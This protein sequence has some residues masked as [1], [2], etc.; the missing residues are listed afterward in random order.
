MEE[1]SVEHLLN[2]NSRLENFIKDNNLGTEFY[3]L[4]K[5]LDIQPTHE[6][7]QI[8]EDKAHADRDLKIGILGR[9]KAG[10]SSF[11]NALVFG[12]QSVL[13]K[14][15]TPMTAALTILEYGESFEA[16]VDFYTPEEVEHIKSKHAQY[17]QLLQEATERKYE[18]FKKNANLVKKKSDAELRENAKKIAAQELS[19]SSLHAHFEQYEQMQQSGIQASSL[20]SA[21][22]VECGSYSELGEKLKDYVGSSG[23]FMPFSKSITLRLNEERLKELKIIDTPGMDDP[24]VSREERTRS[25]IAACDVVFLVSPSGQFL[26]ARDLELLKSIKQKNGIKEFHIVASQ[27]DNVLSAPEIKAGGNLPQSI[28]KALANLTRQQKDIFTSKQEEY[29]AEAC[30]KFS[31]FEV[32]FSSGVSTEIANHYDNLQD[33]NAK[34]VLE[35]LRKNYPDFF[36]TKE[37][38]LSNLNLL[39]NTQKVLQI[40]EQVR[41]QKEA[42]ITAALQE[43]LQ[44]KLKSLE[45]FAKGVASALQ[46]KVD[47]LNTLDLN[48]LKEQLKKLEKIQTKVM[49]IADEA[50]EDTAIALSNKLRE[51]LDQQIK[52]FFRDIERAQ[53]SSQGSRTEERTKRVDKG[54]GFLGWRSLTGNRYEYKTYN[55]TYKTLKASPIRAALQ[56]ATSEI[57]DLL[58][59][60]YN[61]NITIWRK[62]LKED[63]F[64]ALQKGVGDE[65]LDPDVIQSSVRAVIASIQLPAFAYNFSLPSILNQSGELVGDSECEAFLSAAEEYSYSLKERAKSDIKSILNALESA[66]K[67]AQIGTKL[68]GSYKKEIEE[69]EQDAQDK[70]E[71]I[72]RYNA[73]LEQVRQIL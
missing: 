42:I 16:E 69:L 10:K 25:L 71:N 50:F 14:A 40:L 59:S 53:E 8:F 67:G 41:T 35:N 62:Q 2:V 55:I 27:F 47:K 9:V 32:L 60:A 3:A 29:G 52:S 73:L 51:E 57:G 70:E 5:E 49:S 23:K 7:K 31:A 33:P 56:E 12:G 24:I 21:Q 39:A 17:Q 1:V 45:Q 26:N 4:E 63:L 30:A 68:M 66:I 37:S 13:P 19:T 54:M 34:K 15:A 61:K 38:A 36:A 28:Q 46:N 72:R 18:E 65:Y 48:E 11:L 44:S 64:K 58:D 43:T 20:P 22:K 6:L